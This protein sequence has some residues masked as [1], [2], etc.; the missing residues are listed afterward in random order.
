VELMSS[1]RR[2]WILASILLVI[3]LAGSAALYKKLPATYQAESSVVLLAPKNVAKVYGGNPYLA[4]NSAIN[5]TADVVRY[6]TNDA[7]T[8]KALG[9][10]GYASTYLVT[11]AIDTSGPVLVVT[12]TG[13][14]K[15][16]VEKTLGGVTNE[17]TAKLSSLQQ[18]ITTNNKITDVVI[19]FT[20][21]PKVLS[22][23][24]LRPLSVAAG[25]GLILTIGIPVIVDSARRRRPAN[26]G[27][28]WEA[29][30]PQPGPSEITHTGDDRERHP[31]RAPLA[32]SDL[33][34]SRRP[35]VDPERGARRP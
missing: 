12:V 22:S 28:R 5:Q 18:G 6:E 31:R 34:A 30:R 24:K 7:R 35:E 32:R 10:L 29:S 11:D 13:H 20:P 15:A 4:F 25:L 16:V 14:G 21:A 23:K 17:L 26:N 19:T 33:R 9:D 27:P 1:L 3:T 2:N 8:V